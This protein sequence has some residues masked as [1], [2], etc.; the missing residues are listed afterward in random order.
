M[1]G[2]HTF[3]YLVFFFIRTTSEIKKSTPLGIL[4][5]STQKN[6]RF[7]T[8]LIGTSPRN[9]SSRCINWGWFNE[10]SSNADPS[11][12]DL[13]RGSVLADVSVSSSPDIWSST[14]EQER[15]ALKHFLISVSCHHYTQRRACGYKVKAQNL[16]YNPPIK[17]KSSKSYLTETILVSFFKAQ[18]AYVM[19]FAVFL[20]S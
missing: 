18:R 9:F 16:W 12:A 1:S 2:V 3:L 20:K 6:V 14:N 11:V 13:G 7:L 5:E 10:F 4:M 15:K 17:A 8:Y 19:L